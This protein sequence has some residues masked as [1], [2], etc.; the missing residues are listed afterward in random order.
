MGSCIVGHQTSSVVA[1]G[2]SLLLSGIGLLTTNATPSPATYNICNGLS[3]QLL[4]HSASIAVA[5]KK[6]KDVLIP[7]CFIVN[8]VQHTDDPVLP[9]RNNSIPFGDAFD[10]AFFLQQIQQ[11]GIVA[12]LVTFDVEKPQLPCNGMKTLRKANPRIVLKVLKAFRPSEKMSSIISS[13]TNKI[14]DKG[15]GIC[16]HH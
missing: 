9:T 10:Q 5:V 1:L 13:I 6:G 2:L 12:R 7:D 14:K 8:G 15:E 16:V 4:Y 11:L 3:N